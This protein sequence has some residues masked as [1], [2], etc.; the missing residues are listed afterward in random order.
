[1]WSISNTLNR[2]S[3]SSNWFSKPL[4][5]WASGLGMIVPFGK[6]CSPHQTRGERGRRQ[7]PIGIS[8]TGQSRSCGCRWVTRNDERTLGQS[9]GG[10]WSAGIGE[11]ADVGFTSA[12][13]L[14][15]WLWRTQLEL[16]HFYVCYVLSSAVISRYNTSWLKLDAAA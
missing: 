14:I 9:K 2:T 15:S 11:M 4:R 1:M 13:D 6:A 16:V 12:M 10:S 7:R 3:M 8:Q 5:M